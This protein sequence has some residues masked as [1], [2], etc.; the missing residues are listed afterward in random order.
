VAADI[1]SVLPELPE[2]FEKQDSP[3]PLVPE[4]DLG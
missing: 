1:E 3:P 4:A 2:E